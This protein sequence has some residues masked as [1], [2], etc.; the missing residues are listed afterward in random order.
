MGHR[1]K[2]EGE[3]QEAGHFGLG[4]AAALL[5]ITVT[6]FALRVVCIAKWPLWG[7]EALTLLVSQWPLDTLFLRAVDPTPGLYYALH[8]LLLGPMAGTVAAR[9]ISLVA[10]T[11][12]VPLAYWA[13]KAARVP[14]LMTATL[15]ALSFPLI[16]YSQEARAYSVVVLLIAGSAGCFIAWSRGRGAA[17]LA[18]F[19]GC[20]LLAIY[21]HV[22]AWL[23]MGPATVAALALGRRRALLPLI[24]FAVL[25]VP[26]I[27]RLMIFRRDAFSWLLQASPAEAGDTMSRALLPF[28][29]AGWWAVAAAMLL[30]WRCW[31][32][33][34]R[35]AAWAKANIGA[36]IAIAILLSLP[37]TAWLFGFVAK[38]IFMTRTILPAVPGFMLALALLTGF[39]RHPVRAAVIALYAASLLTSGT[40]RTREDWGVIAG[41]VAGGNVLLCQPFQAAALRHELRS[42]ARIFLWYRA[43]L[44]ELRGSPWPAT[45]FRVQ[46]RMDRA[47]DAAERGRAADRRLSP[48]WAIR[49]G[50]ARQLSPAPTDLAGAIRICEAAT[51]DRAPSYRAE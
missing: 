23:W 36:A 34:A 30:A 18:G 48:V 41:R 22:I 40:V 50:D 17:F 37:L 27:R 9:S 19:L 10:G 14:P 51:A 6:A 39:E 31:V 29:P 24:L 46:H 16:D 5:A 4:S 21:T 25:S 20:G 43:G 35:I 15:V 13:A 12:L 7:D 44:L 47:R 2:D 3:A 8:K 45:Y 11:L 33:R 42:D 32:H 49:S 28:Q 1:G 38:P 26:E